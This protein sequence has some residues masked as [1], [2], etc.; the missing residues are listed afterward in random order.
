MNRD[1]S[2]Q[3][4]T[5]GASFADVLRV[6]LEAGWEVRDVTG[7]SYVPASATDVSDWKMFSSDSPSVVLEECGRRESAGLD[8]AL[9]L[10]RQGEDRGGQ[11][12]WLDGRTLVVSLNVNPPDDWDFGRL[13]TEVGRPLEESGIAIERVRVDRC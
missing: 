7:T 4:A 11:F 13:V 2:I 1:L 5:R 10:L 9:V 6:L 8:P 12:L 3:I